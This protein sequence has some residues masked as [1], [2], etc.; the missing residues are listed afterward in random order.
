MR[1]KGLI[2]AD[3]VTFEVIR[4]G[5]YAICEEMKTVL[6][7]TSFSPLLSLSADLSCAILDLT[8]NV[9]AQGN[10]IPVHLGAMP[11]TGRAVLA[12]YP[13]A[14]WEPGDAVLVNDPYLGGTHLP[15]MSLLMPVF[16]GGE[17]LAFSATRVHWPDVG[18]TAAGSSSIS[19]EIFK[20]GLRI[21]PV[22]IIARGELR[23]DIL[24]IILANVRIPDD[25]LG[26]FRAQQ[27]ANRRGVDRLSQIAARYGNDKLAAVLT[28][29][30]Y[31]SDLQ[32]RARLAKLPDAVVDA[33]ETLD[34]DGFDGPGAASLRIQV[35]IRKSGERFDVDFSGSTGPARGPVNAPLPVTASAVYYTMLGFIGGGIPPNSGAYASA[36][37]TAP[38]GSIVNAQYPAPVV[39]A[40]TETSN[41]IVDL[42]L[43]A[44]GKAYPSQVPAGSYGSAC[45]YTLGG[46]DQSRGRSFV[47]YET[48][49]GG[50]GARFGAN[51]P[52]GM[53]VHMGNTMNL[54][55]ES[56]EAAMPLRFHAY[57]LIDESGGHGRW[58]GG[59]GVHKEIEILAD[60]V[61]ASILGERTHTPAQGIGGGAPGG[62]A[63]FAVQRASGDRAELASKSGPHRLSKGDRI[64]LQ[65][66]G[67]GG[68]GSK[69]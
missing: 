64:V 60:R 1:S 27:A 45:V 38:E 17:L 50:M 40:N 57:G 52:D 26:D 11:F 67:G 29:S 58:Q 65:T 25:R 33:S 53:R 13:L 69:D 23:Q 19:D 37:I 66:A 54:P 56:M 30:Q 14:T 34:G 59:K 43:S 51:G 28:D 31:Y 49:G 12:A 63:S 42:L 44:L 8:G 46:F 3:P 21:P 47:H 18:G 4:N 55:I 22:K 6:M 68:W 10:D 15:D 62:P 39:A 2:G 16:H 32:V 41:R 35:C 7:R 20:E 24:K 36:S 5:L 9:A 48:I 61:D